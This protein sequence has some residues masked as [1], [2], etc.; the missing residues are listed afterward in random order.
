MN[1]RFE[2]ESHITSLGSREGTDE[3]ATVD[4]PGGT[5]EFIS[6]VRYRWIHESM[7]YGGT[8][9]FTT[10]DAVKGMEKSADEEVLGAIGNVLSPKMASSKHPSKK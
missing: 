4:I 8:D 6:K 3:F 9:E 7:Y 5:H 10:L 2:S 1:T